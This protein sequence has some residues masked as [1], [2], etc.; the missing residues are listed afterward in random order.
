MFTVLAEDLDDTARAELW[1]KLVA[2]FLRSA[3]SSAGSCDR[4]LCS[5]LLARTEPRQAADLPRRA[6]P[7]DRLGGRTT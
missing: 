1:P 3:N 7:T 4:F 6:V 5:C 2:E